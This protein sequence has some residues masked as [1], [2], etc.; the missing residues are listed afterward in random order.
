VLRKELAAVGPVAARR[1]HKVTVPV[2]DLVGYAHLISYTTSA[3]EGWEPNTPLSNSLPPAPH[4]SSIAQS[5]LF[6]RQHR[7]NKRPLEAQEGPQADDSRYIR[8][9]KHP[10]HQADG[11][12]AALMPPEEAMKPLLGAQEEPSPSRRAIPFS[13][14]VPLQKDSPG[15]HMAESSLGADGIVTLQRPKVV[16]PSRPPGWRP[17]D[18]ISVS[19]SDIARPTV[20][21][22]GGSG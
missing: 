1:R 9:W 2:D 21:A 13:I 4:V 11:D 16:L 3:R 19:G 15:R 17:G 12:E 10:Q 22:G 18:A 6:T 5:R 8:M 14:P 20:A 7:A